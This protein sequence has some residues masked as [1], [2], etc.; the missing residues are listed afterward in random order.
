MV[1]NSTLMVIYDLI[2]QYNN[3]QKDI[4]NIAFQVESF[5]A[6]EDNLDWD[7]KL[8]LILYLEQTNKKAPKPQP[9]MPTLPIPPMPQMAG[10]Q[11]PVFFI[12]PDTDGSMPQPPER[13]ISAIETVRDYPLTSNLFLKICEKIKDEK[14]AEQAQV[15]LKLKEL[16][17]KT[18]Y[19]SIKPTNHHGTEQSKRKQK[20]N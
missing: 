15:V 20:S 4:D 3:L 6:K 1:K 14:V 19:K 5:M 16:G 11:Q 2:T 7:S 10:M 18:N 9:K 17:V 13:E 12:I 8:T